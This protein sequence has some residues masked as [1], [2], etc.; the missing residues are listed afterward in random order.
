MNSDQQ[1]QS[2]QLSPSFKPQQLGQT[3]QKQPVSQAA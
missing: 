1:Q 3:S 2:Q